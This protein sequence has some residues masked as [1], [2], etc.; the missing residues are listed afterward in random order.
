MKDKKNI[1]IFA[2][3]TI[4]LAMILIIFGIIFAIFGDNWNQRMMLDIL[5]ETG[6]ENYLEEVFPGVKIGENLVDDINTV[7]L[8][9][10]NDI[11][12][13]IV[14]YY[15]IEYNDNKYVKFSDYADLMKSKFN[16][17][18]TI[19]DIDDIVSLNKL[20][21]VS[22]CSYITSTEYVEKCQ[23]E[24]IDSCY[25]MHSIFIS[26]NGKV[27]FENLNKVGNSIR[28]EIVKKV[29]YNDVNYDYY[30]TF[31]LKFTKNGSSYDINSFVVETFLD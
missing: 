13:I 1:K 18:V 27:S 26:E 25:F 20:Q 28:G 17:T 4:V 15:E 16:K 3:I 8:L 22:K 29:E 12:P 10:G 5:K 19:D 2:I 6:V 7:N 24:N 11:S 30:G 23:K 31:E 9:S 14:N 21:E